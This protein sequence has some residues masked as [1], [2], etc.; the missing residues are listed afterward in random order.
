LCWNLGPLF[1]AHILL[2]LQDEGQELDGAG[3]IPSLLAVSVPAGLL[4]LDA[5]GFSLSC[6][7]IS[8]RSCLR[9]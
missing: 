9:V 1:D 3:M 2:L 5:S 4:I 6:W 8:A 7:Y